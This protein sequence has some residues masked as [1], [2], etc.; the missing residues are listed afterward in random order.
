MTTRNEQ[1]GGDHYT[2][3]KV[4][5]WDVIDEYQ[6]NFWLGNVIKYILRHQDKNGIEDLRKALHYLQHEIERLESQKYA[7]N[8]KR[9]CSDGT[10]RL[11]ER[12]QEA[13]RERMQ[14][15]KG[16]MPDEVADD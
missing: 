16:L 15:S 13:M 4:Q 10:S 9:Q 11:V 2:K 12:M 3:H 5:P 6:L 7:A 1:V 8:L 14:I